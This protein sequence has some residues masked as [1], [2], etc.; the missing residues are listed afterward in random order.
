MK[1]SIILFITIVILTVGIAAVLIFFSNEYYYKNNNVTTTTR[2]STSTIT[3]P[4]TT[5]STSTVTT[6]AVPQPVTNTPPAIYTSNL[7]FPTY[8]QYPNYP[9]GC[10]TIA[11]YILLQY[12]GVNVTP[13]QLIDAL[14]TKPLKEKQV[15]GTYCYN[16]AEYN[17]LG[18]PRLEGSSRGVF[19]EP[20]KE[21]ANKFKP[22]AKTVKGI[23]FTEVEKIVNSGKPV[24]AWTTI[25][26]EVSKDSFLGPECGTGNTLYWKTREH[27]LVVIATDKNYVVVSDPINGEIRYFDRKTF[28]NRYNRMDKRI[29]YYG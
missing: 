16:N 21:L 28:I 26:L 11:L 19:N 9:T 15:D 29:V 3:L 5:I 24:I 27:A 17:F 13:D 2:T 20:I 23:E 8:N 6:T 1:K 10:E 14:P 7:N 22:G 18:N 25:N 4:T 12:Y